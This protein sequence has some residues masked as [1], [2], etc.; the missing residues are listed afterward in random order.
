MKGCVLRL[1]KRKKNIR[2]KIKADQGRS[3]RGIITSV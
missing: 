1:K 2:M 3:E